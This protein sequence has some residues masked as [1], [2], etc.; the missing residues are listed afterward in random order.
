V[1]KLVVMSDQKYSKKVSDEKVQVWSD[2][3]S[4]QDD[5][6][7]H[8]EFRSKRSKK[9]LDQKVA[10]KSR[11]GR[12]LPVGVPEVTRPSRPLSITWS[13][14]EQT[15]ESVRSVSKKSKT[16][17]PS[18]GVKK[19][20]GGQRGVSKHASGGSVAS[21]S[22]YWLVTDNQPGRIDH[23][24]ELQDQSYKVYQ[25]EAGEEAGHEHYQL[26][27]E[28]TKKKRFNAVQKLFQ[29]SDGGFCHIEKRKG[30]RQEAR[31]YCMK[32]D[33][34]VEGPWEFGEWTG[35]KPGQRND[36]DQIRDLLQNGSSIDA[37]AKQFPS[38]YIRYTKGI[39]A[40][41]R[42]CG[43]PVSKPMPRG[44]YSTVVVGPPGV[45]KDLMITLMTD[46]KACVMNF[47]PGAEW[48]D[49]YNREECLHV[50]EYSGQLPWESLLLILDPSDQHVPIKGSMI[51]AE[52]KRVYFSTNVH[53]YQWYSEPR[54]QKHLQAL[55]RR[56]SCLM[57]YDAATATFVEDMK[58]RDARNLVLRRAG[59]PINESPKRVIAANVQKWMKDLGIAVVDEVSQADVDFAKL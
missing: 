13:P 30:T 54:Y 36:F 20:S 49:A 3:E 48:Y 50:Q 41:A 28:F 32:V 11:T 9:V 51:K 38:Q 19:S 1:L 45:G 44:I 40:I 57:E 16:R 15:S 5:Y 42:V 47:R 23:D 29:Y 22:M 26:Y 2:V 33:S 59:L 58:H 14:Q 56:I 55:I 8:H 4:N 6:A 37:I 17:P 31:D 39:Q 53:P 10:V 27:V 46:K 7:R 35:P 25:L 52:W 21:P 12:I 24:L 34:R 43:A 18:K